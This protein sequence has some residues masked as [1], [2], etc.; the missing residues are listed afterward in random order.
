M[1]DKKGISLLVLIITIIVIAIL[2]GAVILTLLNSGVLDSSKKATFMSDYRTVQEG[3]NL[4]ALGKYNA[5]TGEF[6]LPLKGYLNEEDKAYIKDYV[7]TLNTKIQELSGEIDTTELAWI[8]SEDVGVKLSDRKTE[9]G[10]IMDV[11][12]GQIYDYVG[13]YFEGKRWHTLDGGIVS[14]GTNG[15]GPQVVEELW[16]GWIR[17]TLYYPSNSTE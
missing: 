9:K 1:K 17:L 14:D 3:V 15:G 7:P 11:K 2:A 16:N 13:D 10:Y 4:Y 6:E 12:N 5:T 8:S